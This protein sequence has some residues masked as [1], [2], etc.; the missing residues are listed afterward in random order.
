MSALGWF[1]P[2]PLPWLAYGEGPLWQIVLASLVAVLAGSIYLLQCYYDLIPPVVILEVVGP[3]AVLFPLAVVFAR[4]IQRRSTP[5][6]TLFAFPACWTAFEFLSEFAAPNGTYGS[7][8]YSQ[9]SAPVLIQSASLF[10]LHS[11]TFLLKHDHHGHQ[12]AAGDGPRDRAG[13]GSLR[14][15]RGVRVR[16]LG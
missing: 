4:A 16:A 10:G 6:V 11:V 2:V 8:A 3:Q 12:G 14:S 1:A 7:F 9:V 5:L 13:A 15:E